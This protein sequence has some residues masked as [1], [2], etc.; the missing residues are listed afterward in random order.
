MPVADL[1]AQPSR[2][3]RVNPA[4][5]A[6]HG[7]RRSMRA[8]GDRLLQSGVQRGTPLWSISTPER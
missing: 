7:D 3:E 1:R 2:G 4:E 6:Q 8:I 5:A